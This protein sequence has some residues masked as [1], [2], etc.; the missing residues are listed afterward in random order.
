MNELG[1]IVA[2]DFAKVLFQLPARATLLASEQVEQSLGTL[3]PAG[4]LNIQVT[5]NDSISRVANADQSTGKHGGIIPV[6]Q[7]VPRFLNYLHAAYYN[8][9]SHARE[10]G[11]WR[12]KL[13]IDTLDPFRKI[14]T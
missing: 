8:G 13:P 10:P 2:K 6:S 9:E 12:P 7:G 4:I 1:R 5:G 11:S 3:A 14:S